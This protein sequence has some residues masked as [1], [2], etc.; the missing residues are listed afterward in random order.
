MQ[1][2]HG[3]IRPPDSTGKL[4]TNLLSKTAKGGFR[5]AQVSRGLQFPNFFQS[6]RARAIATTGSLN[7]TQGRTRFPAHFP[8]RPE[9]RLNLGVQLLERVFN[10][11]SPLSRGLFRHHKFNSSHFVTIDAKTRNVQSFLEDWKQGI[12]Q[13]ICIKAT[14]SKTMN[15]DN[16]TNKS[17]SQYTSKHISITLIRGKF[18]LFKNRFH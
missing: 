8:F 5:N 13:N 7:P 3:K 6:L 17:F 11:R 10:I 12:M 16:C 15:D 2:F 4:L 14:H 1:S 9:R 18:L